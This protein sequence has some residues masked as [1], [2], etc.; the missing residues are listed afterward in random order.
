M[1]DQKEIRSYL[2]PTSTYPAESDHPYANNYL[3]TWTISEPGA[4]QIRIHFEKIDLK[5]GD[6]VKILDEDGNYLVV[7]GGSSANIYYQYLKENFWT[8]WYVGDTLKVEFSTNPTGTSYGFLVD[9]KETRETSPTPTSTSI[10]TPTSTPISIPTPTSTPI[11]IPTPTSTPI[12]IPTPT[13][14]P[15][16]I[17][18]P[19]S[20][21]I[22]IPTPTSTP[23]SIPTPTP[24]E[25]VTPFTSQWQIIIISLLTL[26][27]AILTFLF[28]HGILK[29]NK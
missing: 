16:S 11:S 10:L 13:S 6:Y 25:K 22:S 2:V 23:I 27:I 9:Q 8:D 4:S 20:T 15:I 12:S 28:G 14:T 29:R 19:T 3:N 26:I 17:P 7:Y 24:K 21:P 1:V 5:S 18:T